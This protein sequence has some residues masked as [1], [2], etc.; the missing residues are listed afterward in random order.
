MTP[1]EETAAFQDVPIEIGVELDRPMIK[2]R[3]ILNFRRGTVIEMKRSAGENLDIY[4]G[5]KLIGSG[6]LVVIE[7]TMGVRITDF[8]TET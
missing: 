8:L 1:L 2:I 6:E 3:D 7:N 4:M 5:K